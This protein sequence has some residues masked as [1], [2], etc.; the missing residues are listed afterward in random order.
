[1]FAPPLS[2]LLPPPLTQ[3]AKHRP[4]CT[5][6]PPPPRPSS[7]PSQPPTAGVTIAVP[8][9]PTRDSI[10][11]KVRD[12]PSRGKVMVQLPFFVVQHYSVLKLGFW[13][14][15]QKNKTQKGS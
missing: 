3:I 14:K 9:S 6:P 13:T 8:A 5:P 7:L 11:S 4:P 2:P 1:M 12:T 15:K 10:S